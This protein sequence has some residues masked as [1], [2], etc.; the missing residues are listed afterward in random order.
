[1]FIYRDVMLIRVEQLHANGCFLS[2]ILAIIYI[3]KF[4][5]YQAYFWRWL[6]EFITI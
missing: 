6:I 1:M 5:F 4:R 3:K 2:F